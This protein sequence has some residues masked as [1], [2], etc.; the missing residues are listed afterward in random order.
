MTVSFENAIACDCVHKLDALRHGSLMPEYQ[1]ANIDA[2]MA[3]SSSEGVV[4]NNSATACDRLVAW[5][6]P[7][8]ALI[9]ADDRGWLGSSPPT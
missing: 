7:T 5:V 9:S 4:S 6:R 2:E 1:A 3:A 8:L